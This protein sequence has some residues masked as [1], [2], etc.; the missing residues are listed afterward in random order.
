MKTII[1]ICL[2]VSACYSLQA[3]PIVSSSPR[4]PSAMH[5][6]Q[7]HSIDSA[8]RSNLLAKTGG[9]LLTPVKGPSILFLN[10]Q[11]RV[12]VAVASVPLDTIHHILH[13]PVMMQSK[14]S[15]EPLVDAMTALKDPKIAA[16]VVI[17]DCE[18]Y[19][20]LLVAPESRWAMVNVAALASDCATPEKLAE[21]VQ[22]EIWRSFGYVMGAANSPTELC[23]LK[24]VF[25]NA[26]LD[27]LTYKSLSAGVFNRIMAQAFKLGITPSRMATY[28]KAVEEGW[29]PAPTNDFQRAIWQELKQ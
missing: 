25:S 24:P 29:A 21:R 17:A 14:T 2:F 23:L 8:T 15:R 28:R 10:T 18:G 27:M 1:C 12:P 7:I 19:P 13:L 3:Q 6:L 4:T 5:P 16:V 22:K 26:D 11:S 20:S 9:M